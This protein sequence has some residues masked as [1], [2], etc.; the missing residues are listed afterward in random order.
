[1]CHGQR[2]Q[3]SEA[4]VGNSEVEGDPSKGAMRNYKDK[5]EASKYTVGNGHR[6]VKWLRA[7]A[8]PQ[9]S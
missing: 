9:V 1:M 6:Q 2:P 7:T 3:V 8:M 5:G 4:T